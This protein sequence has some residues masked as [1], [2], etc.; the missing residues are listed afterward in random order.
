MRIYNS[1]KDFAKYSG[2]FQFL[3]S[4]YLV[5][6][7]FCRFLNIKMLNGCACQN[8]GNIFVIFI[9]WLIQPK[10]HKQNTHV[11]L[12]PKSIIYVVEFTYK[13]FRLTSYAYRKIGYWTQC[14]TYQKENNCFVRFHLPLRVFSPLLLQRAFKYLSIRI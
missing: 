13:V 5:S 14:N 11:S 2:C 7:T 6:N 4:E 12:R 1:E 3:G 9:H 8:R 10:G